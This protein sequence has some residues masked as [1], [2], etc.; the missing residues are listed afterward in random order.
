MS[1]PAT[2]AAAWWRPLPGRALLAWRRH[3]HR[4]R[5]RDRGFLFQQ[6]WHE[7]LRFETMFAGDPQASPLVLLHGFLDSALTFRRLAPELAERYRIVAV[8][9]PG[10]GRTRWPEVR[11][12]WRIPLIARAVAGFLFDR[13]QLPRADFLT[14]SM[15]GLV[16]AH[17]LQYLQ[18][19]RQAKLVRSVHMLA[20]GMLQ[21]HAAER[22]Q[23]RRMVYPQTREEV[24][25]LVARFYVESAPQLP[26]LIIDGL[27]WDWS[28]RGYEYLAQNTIE[29]ES[30]VFFSPRALAALPGALHIYWCER[31]GVLP[32]WMAEEYRR[33]CRRQAGWYF[34]TIADSGHAAHLE[35]PERV[36]RALN[37]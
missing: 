34:R 5:L 6:I 10:F 3:R 7:G 19:R 21:M 33:I 24:R 14:H 13:L 22:E 8:D 36:L 28:R 30:E 17:L 31:E 16:G 12:L 26:A 32:A 18:K 15:G 20:P 37:L 27:L 9:L 35:H 2:P 25:D 1:S 11:D 23:L 29:D 4:S